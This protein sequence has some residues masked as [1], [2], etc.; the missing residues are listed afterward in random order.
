MSVTSVTSDS[1]RAP[2]AHSYFNF[3]YYSHWPDCDCC[4]ADNTLLPVAAALDR[5]NCGGK[6]R[7][8]AKGGRNF[9]QY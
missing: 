6:I 7:M 3:D 5:H 1:R 2:R 4:S 9:A 8:V